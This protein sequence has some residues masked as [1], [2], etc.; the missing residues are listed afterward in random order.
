MVG[1]ILY[2][3]GVAFASSILCW[4]IFLAARLFVPKFDRWICIKFFGGVYCNECRF[5]NYEFD[6]CEAKENKKPATTRSYLYK[7]I[8]YD[9]KRMPSLQNRNNNCQ[10]YRRCK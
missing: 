7:V 6:S 4:I 8:V 9:Y 3:L 2:V 1:I 10:F 5:Y